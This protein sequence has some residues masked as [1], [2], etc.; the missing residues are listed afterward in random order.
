MIGGKR[1]ENDLERED[2]L[3]ETIKESIENTKAVIATSH[4]ESLS[5]ELNLSRVPKLFRDSD[6]N[7]AESN[8][9]K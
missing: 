4:E 5:E 8:T 1:N 9:S 2:G 6:L 3:M 7:V